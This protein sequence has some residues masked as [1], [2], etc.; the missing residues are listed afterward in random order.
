[1][2]ICQGWSWHL[3]IVLTAIKTSWS[4]SDADVASIVEEAEATES[5]F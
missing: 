3:G 2:K 1:M 4:D 5:A